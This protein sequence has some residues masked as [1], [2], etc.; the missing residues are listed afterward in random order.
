MKLPDFPNEMN[1]IAHIGLQGVARP[2][3]CRN[4]KELCLP[5]VR[6]HFVSCFVVE[7][8][9]CGVRDILVTWWFVLWIKHVN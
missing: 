5:D 8:W 9:D 3:I 1:G 2:K 7:S 4:T 6:S